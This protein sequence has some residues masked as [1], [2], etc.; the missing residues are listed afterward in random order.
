MTSDPIKNQVDEEFIFQLDKHTSNE[1]V[2]SLIQDYIKQ[3]VIHEVD[4]ITDSD[5][6]TEKIQDAVE[7]STND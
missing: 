5:W 1:V 6:F 7:D 4:I 3:L 2:S